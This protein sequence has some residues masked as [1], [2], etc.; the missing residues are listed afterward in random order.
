VTRA[1]LVPGARELAEGRALLL[2]DGDLRIAVFRTGDRWL[3]FDDACPH[4]MGPLSEGTL[5]FT[6]RGVLVTCPFHG[7]QYDLATGACATVRG[8]AVRTYPV[9]VNAAGVHVI[10]PGPPGAP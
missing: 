6:P 1:I 5:D 7:W 10:V 2:E 9:R 3:A 4:R 8:P